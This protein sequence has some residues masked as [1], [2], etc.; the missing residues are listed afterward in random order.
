VNP[1]GGLML[2]AYKAY[3]LALEEEFGGWPKGSRSHNPDRAKALL[4]KVLGEH[5]RYAKY[6]GA[7]DQLGLYYQDAPVFIID[8]IRLIFEQGTTESDDAFLVSIAGVIFPDY[9]VRSFV[10]LGATLGCLGERI[11][12][13][14]DAEDSQARIEKEDKSTRKLLDEVQDMLMA[15]T[16]GKYPPSHYYEGKGEQIEPGQARVVGATQIPTA[17][18]T[19]GAL[20]NNQPKGETLENEKSTQKAQ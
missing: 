12:E 16:L 9:R 3:L 18:M 8:E 10:Q 15:A 11:L 20:V 17:T 5:Y 7:D 19:L 2:D 1:A 13:D 4:K 14:A 6:L